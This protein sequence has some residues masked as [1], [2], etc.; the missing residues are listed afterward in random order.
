MDF[1]P[2]RFD[3][4]KC[5]L[6]CNFAEMAMR[7]VLRL[8]E[9]SQQLRSSPTPSSGSHH[10]HSAILMVLFVGTLIQ[11]NHIHLK[12]EMSLALVSSSG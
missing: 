8:S 11:I 3:A 2:R 9:L 5:N 6:L 4:E 1:K 10:M 7:D 12:G